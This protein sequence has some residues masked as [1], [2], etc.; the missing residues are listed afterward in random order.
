MA[1]LLAFLHHVAAFTLV[2][3]LTAEF[4]LLKSE[5]TL[6]SARRIRLIDLAF[7]IAAATVLTVGLLRVF[8]FE[9]GAAYY[10][11]SWPFIAKL[12]MFFVV[13]VLSIYP[14]IEFLSWG[15]AVKQGQVPSVSASTMRRLRTVMHIELVG[16]VAI[17]LFAVLM[18]RGIGV[19]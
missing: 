8:W 10:F 17:I 18:A 15:K 11:H 13:G 12:S 16:V 4:I 5:L 14:T 9:K 3:A 19:F 7:G 1:A 2:A 6:Q